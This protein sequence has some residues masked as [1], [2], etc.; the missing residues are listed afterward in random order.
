MTTS[1]RVFIISG[2][3]SGDLHGAH[4]VQ[5]LSHHDLQ[6]YAMGGKQLAAAG[7]NIIVDSTA[8][9]VV[10]LVEIA[11]KLTLIWRAF[12]TIT[13]AIATYLPKLIILIDYPGFNLRLAKKIK[14]THPE[15]KILY[16]ISPQ[17][18]AWRYQRIKKIKQYV[19]LMAVIFPFE[20]PIYQKKHVPVKFVGHP[21]IAQVKSSQSVT[22][23]RSS[24]GFDPH[25]KM[26]Q[27]KQTH[28]EIKFV[29]PLAASL[30][31]SDLQPFL[32]KTSLN[33]LVIGH[34]YDVIAMCDALIVTSG[35]ATLEV[36][37][38]NKPMVV[39]YKLSALTYFIAKFLVKVPYIALCNLVAETQV[40]KELLQRNASPTQIAAEITR[41]L[42]D[43]PYREQIRNRLNQMHHKLL[44]H[45]IS[46]SL[47]AIVMSLTH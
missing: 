3:A 9:A 29:L 24:L 21:L 17:I 23:I 42:F 32:A 30:N 20:V 40:A 5:A 47:P 15:I 22:A 1:S 7:A 14:Q 34:S 38:L 6:F 45:S 37:M 46:E 41:L 13:Q 12:K 25:C 18:W 10:G 16:Y 28:P 36:A 33:I 8:L 27:L 4:L 31:Q 2:E 11:S 39:V 26:Q 35:T 44:Q 19:D 43:L